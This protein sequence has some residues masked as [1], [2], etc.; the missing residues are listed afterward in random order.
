MQAL[1]DRI[2]GW[3][4]ARKTCEA[5]RDLIVELSH[6]R[7]FH[8]IDW[9]PLSTEMAALEAEYAQLARDS[10]MLR[11]LETQLRELEQVMEDTDK[12]LGE[13][14]REC[15]QAQLRQEQ[16]QAQRDECATLLDATPREARDAYF[17]R[18]ETM[19]DEALGEHTLSVE[20]CDNR[21]REMREWLT[22]NIDNADRS[23]AGLRDRIIDAMRGYQN[24]WP[25]DSREVV[26]RVFIT[27]NEINGLAF[28][29][30]PGS[31]VIFGLGYGLERLA[32]IPWLTEVEIHYWGD[33]D[34]HGFAILDRLR[35]RLP[36]TR[37][38]LMDRATL[39][40]HRDLW[41]Q[42]HPQQ[43]FTGTLTRLTPPEQSLFEDLRENRLGECVR[44][45]QE[46]IGYGGLLKAIAPRVWPTSVQM[47]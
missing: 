9:R 5:R 45:E 34:T 36:H 17:P 37:S 2:G 41:G 14:Q 44:L 28:P 21:E 6:F 8:D 40:A 35:A 11:A 30:T 10:D 32:D 24:A 20:S 3:E 47:S 13:A 31:L 29:D 46:R 33:I 26:A 38:L 16:A 39:E 22:R 15:S 19:R 23:A 43:R 12:A 18:L 7:D 1:G 4:Q 27:E 25:L 42:E